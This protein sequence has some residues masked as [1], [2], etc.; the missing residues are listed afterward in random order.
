MLRF[1]IDTQLPPK[2]LLRF[3]SRNGVFYFLKFRDFITDLVLKDTNRGGGTDHFLTAAVNAVMDFIS[4]LR[5]S[6]SAPSACKAI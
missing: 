5:N 2:L 4:T 3:V 6:T 1:I